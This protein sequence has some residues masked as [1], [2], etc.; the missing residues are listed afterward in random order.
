MLAC[1][2]R[3]LSCGSAT[4]VLVCMAY[5]ATWASLRGHCSI[6]PTT[7]TSTPRAPCGSRLVSVR[8]EA[9]L[10]STRRHWT[11]HLGG[12]KL[13][14]VQG[15]LTCGRASAGLV[16]GRN[17]VDKVKGAGTKSTRNMLR[18]AD[19]SVA[20]GVREEPGDGQGNGRT[21]ASSN[22]RPDSSTGSRQTWLV[23]GI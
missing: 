17:R 4:D 1:A 19:P 21:R 14:Q 16:S 9:D 20:V 5:S 10:D 8:S 18:A 7:S 2:V 6:Y 3:L 15:Q 13:S 22:A 23:S 12:L 11:A